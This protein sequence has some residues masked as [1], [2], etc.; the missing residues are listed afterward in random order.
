MFHIDP[1]LLKS[2]MFGQ[3]S[4]VANYVFREIFAEMILKF[5]TKAI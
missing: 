5:I 3:F 4:S 1:A 2:V